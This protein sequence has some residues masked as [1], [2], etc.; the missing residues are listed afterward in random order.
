MKRTSGLFSARGSL[1]DCLTASSFVF[2]CLFFMLGCGGA[3]GEEHAKYKQQL[4]NM[5]KAGQL[6]VQMLA[7]EEVMTMPDGSRKAT[8][9]LDTWDMASPSHHPLRLACSCWHNVAWIY[10]NNIDCLCVTSAVTILAVYCSESCIILT[11]AAEFLLVASS[12]CHAPQML[13]H[14]G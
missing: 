6:A 2:L 14:C 7:A 4:D 3:G 8:F 13:E 5:L 9:L 10:C 1:H 11:A 12:G